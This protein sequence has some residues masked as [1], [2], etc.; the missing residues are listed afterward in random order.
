MLFSMNDY[1]LPH[2][3]SGDVRV[4]WSLDQGELGSHAVLL[5]QEH[6]TV[7]HTVDRAGGEYCGDGLITVR[8][9]ISLVVQ[10]ADCVPVFFYALSGR[11]IGA[12]HAG[13]RGTA[14]NISGIMV[15]NLKLINRETANLWVMIGHCIRDCHYKIGKDVADQFC[16]YPGALIKRK[17]KMYLDL[18]EV[19]RQQL[20]AAGVVPHA[21]YDAGG[22]TY[23]NPL[24][25]SYRRD[26]EGCG[27]IYHCIILT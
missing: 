16:D 4:R 24:L 23:C 5:I 27:S 20:I 2:A 15:Q 6:G 8:A 14:Q 1:T 19:N 21:I 26:G 13:W 7:I 9:G 3:I 11:V 25:P 10:T 18:V 17:G 22:C 12:V